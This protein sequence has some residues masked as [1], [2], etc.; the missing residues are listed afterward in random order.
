LYK[1]AQVK[2][3]IQFI[4][5]R[6]SEAFEN[7]D[8]TVMIKIE[9]TLL[10]KPLKMN[11]DLLVLLVGMQPSRGIA[12]ILHDLEVEIDADGFLKQTDS[13]LTPS[14]TNVPGVFAVG[15]V[16]GPKTIE[17]TISDARAVTVEIANYLHNKVASKI[18]KNESYFI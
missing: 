10:A 16:T 11:L 17:E 3:H 2:H 14:K 12:K 7:Q 8:S 5:G 6:L 18:L 1:E 15:T 4:R 13:H 9:D